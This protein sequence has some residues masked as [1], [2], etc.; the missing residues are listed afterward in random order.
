[1][2]NLF[3][4]T[5]TADLFS[6]V[7]RCKQAWDKPQ[8]LMSFPTGAGQC[9]AG[10]TRD[11]NWPIGI[12]MCRPGRVGGFWWIEVM[13]KFRTAAG[14]YRQAARHHLHGRRAFQILEQFRECEYSFWPSINQCAAWHELVRGID[15]RGYYF[16]HATYW[17]TRH[18]HFLGFLSSKMKYVHLKQLLPHCAVTSA[19]QLRCREHSW[20][21]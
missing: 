6:L 12:S 16:C 2:T 18:R 19:I 11:L 1:V 3:I 9:S 21:Q 4:I 17:T 10:A 8:R 5:T 13:A 20:E 14:T 7:H 15:W